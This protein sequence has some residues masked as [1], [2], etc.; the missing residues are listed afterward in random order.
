MIVTFSGYHAT[1]TTSKIALSASTAKTVLQ[2][3]AASTNALRVLSWGVY[4]DGVDPTGA[5]VLCRMLRQTTA[6]TMSAAT[7][8]GCNNAITYTPT[9]TA[10]HTATA[11]PTAGAVIKSVLV[12]PQQ[13]YEWVA[14]SIE[15]AITVEKSTRLGWECTAGGTVNV[16]AWVEF[17][18]L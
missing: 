17:L 6:G 10:Q 8:V 15:Q 1:V 18:E 11:E 9:A 14:P 3:V 16:L 7:V 2:L 13:G 12:H 5:P 4:F